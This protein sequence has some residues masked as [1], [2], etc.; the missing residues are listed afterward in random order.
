MRRAIFH[1]YMAKTYAQK[2]ALGVV[3]V[4]LTIHKVPKTFHFVLRTRKVELSQIAKHVKKKLVA[5]YL[6]SLLIK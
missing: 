1:T 4:V 5:T 2:R 6:L 3:I